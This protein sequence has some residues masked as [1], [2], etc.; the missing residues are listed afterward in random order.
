VEGDGRV[1]LALDCEL[2]LRFQTD[3]Q[4][5]GLAFAPRVVKANLTLQELNSLQFSLPQDAGPGEN[6]LGA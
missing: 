6:A 3:Q 2:E 5:P 1:E 4:H